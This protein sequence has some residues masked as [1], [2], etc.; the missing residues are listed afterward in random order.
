MCSPYSG[1]RA[2]DLEA[3]LFN[4]SRHDFIVGLN[5]RMNDHLNLGKEE[6]DGAEEEGEGDEEEQGAAEE[7]ELI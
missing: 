2:G 1:V 3:D 6:E 5:G 7:E 4:N